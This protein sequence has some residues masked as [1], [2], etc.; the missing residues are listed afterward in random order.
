MILYATGLVEGAA[1][2]QGWLHAV[3]SF[4]TPFRMPD[5]FLLSGLLLARVIERDWRTYLDRK[6]DHFAYFY[7][8]GSPFSS[9]SNRMAARE[10]WSAVAAWPCRSRHRA[11]AF[12][13]LAR[14]ARQA[15]P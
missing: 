14:A 11:G 13:E 6:V 3:V 5:F 2:R 8:C 1:G 7:S 10:G 15:P 12:P 9:H 4:A